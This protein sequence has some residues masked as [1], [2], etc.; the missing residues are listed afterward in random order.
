MT[1]NVVDFTGTT[2]ADVPVENV[3]D[4]AKKEGL[5]LVFVIGLHP[6][7][8]EVYSASSTGDVAEI[9]LLLERW[10]HKLLS[11]DYD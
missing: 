3:L 8:D 7:S 11:G 1:D 4:G 2:F 5:D 10:K 6:D 9:L